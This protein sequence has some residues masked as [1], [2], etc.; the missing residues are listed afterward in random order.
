MYVDDIIFRSNEESMSQK[1][2]FVMQQ[3]L[4]MSLLGELKY[5][6]GLQVQKTTY[7]IF[8]SQEKYLKK[9]RKKYGMEYYKH[10]S[11]PMVI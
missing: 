6:V 1:F 7:G 9:I 8:L 5:F 11:T 4:E 10:G 2:S 3:G